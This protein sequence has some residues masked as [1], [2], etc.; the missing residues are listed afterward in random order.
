MDFVDD[1]MWMSKIKRNNAVYDTCTYI[2]FYLLSKLPNLS[3]DK[4]THTYGSFLFCRCIWY[5][6]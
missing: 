6:L 5:I 3:L 4:E 2:F 1:K